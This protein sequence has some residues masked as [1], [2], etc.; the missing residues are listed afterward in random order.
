MPPYNQILLKRALNALGRSI[1]IVGGVSYG[2]VRTLDALTA[3]PEPDQ[4]FPSDTF[5]EAAYP[6]HTYPP[7]TYPKAT[8]ARFSATPPPPSATPPPSAATQPPSNATQPPSNAAR[9]LDLAE[10]AIRRLE[11][12]IE[13]LAPPPG[14]THEAEERDA[15]ENAELVT[16]AEL[17]SALERITGT[18]E[19]GIERRFEVQN[20]SVESLR[21]MIARTDELLEQVLESIESG[22]VSA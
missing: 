6:S 2:V 3:E 4:A 15:E 20:L 16:R 17:D 8:S 18:I 22:G 7:H 9:R 21:T 10:A 5:H 12:T 19:A 1:L 14:R 13:A 11:K